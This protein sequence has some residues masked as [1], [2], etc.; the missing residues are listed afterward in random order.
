MSD[1]MKAPVPPNGQAAPPVQASATGATSSE[2][3]FF[4]YDWEEGNK[5]GMKPGKETFKTKEELAKRLREGTL[6]H[7]GFT[8]KTQELAR[9][10][11]EMSKREKQIEAMLA[12]L[13]EKKARIDPMDKFLTDRK[14]IA[15]YIATQMRQPSG[16]AQEDQFKRLIEEYTKPLQDK[17]T[18]AEQWRKDQEETRQWEE[19]HGALGKQYPDFQRDSVEQLL[20]SLRETPEGEENRALAEMAYWAAKGKSVPAV[21]AEHKAAQSLRDKAGKFSPVPSVNASPVAPS[22]SIPKGPKAFQEAVDNYKK[23]HPE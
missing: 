2:S 22:V 11:E 23:A 13:S 6:F 20:Q 4:E 7:S 12:D 21:V 8:V 14:D 9:Q 19:I 1:P 5:A 3:P 16:A 17:L 10:R 15:D 18:E